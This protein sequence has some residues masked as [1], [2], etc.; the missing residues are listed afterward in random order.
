MLKAFS[1]SFFCDKIS[2]MIKKERTMHI[3]RFKDRKWLISAA[4][5]ILADQIVKYFVSHNLSQSDSVVIIPHI[6]NFIYVKNTGAAFSIL[7]D[8]T[9]V[10]GFVSILFCIGVLLF[11]YYKKPQHTLFKL[12]LTLLFSGAFANAIDRIFRGFVVDFIET[13]FI[14][15]PVFNIADIAITFGTI[16]LM[17]YLLFFDKDGHKDGETDN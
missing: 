10:L 5:I 4:L 9:A 8:K 1:F 6:F 14:K 3:M 15:F 16:L 17:I 12:S 13:D 7:S 2:R 11:W